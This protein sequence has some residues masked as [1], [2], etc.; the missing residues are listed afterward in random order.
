MKQISVEHLHA[1]IAAQPTLSN[2]ALARQLGVSEATVRRYRKGPAATEQSGLRKG[3]DGK[4]YKLRP[5]KIELDDSLLAPNLAACIQILEQQST[6]KPRL[7]R[8]FRFL[9]N[10]YKTSPKIKTL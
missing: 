7:A 2:R 4:K 9:A 5:N 1:A 3:L 6:A 10:L 8:T